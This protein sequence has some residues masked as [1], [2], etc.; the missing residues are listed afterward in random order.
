V[1]GKISGVY[2]QTTA[3]AAEIPNFPIM[4]NVTL[5]G[6]SDVFPANSNAKHEHKSVQL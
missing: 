1:V 3:N 5:K 2:K 6:I 4:L